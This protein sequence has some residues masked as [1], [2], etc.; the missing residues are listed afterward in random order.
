MKVEERM[1]RSTM[2]SNFTSSVHLETSTPKQEQNT[3]PL[4][5]RLAWALGLSVK[6]YTKLVAVCLARHAGS[7]TGLAWP[8]LGLISQTTGLSRS[9]V[10][11][12]VAELEQGGHLAVT[13]LKVGKKNAANRYRLPRMGSAVSA[14]PPSAEVAHN[15]MVTPP[16]VCETPP[17]VCETPPPSVCV[18]PEPVRTEP[19]KEPKQ[20]ATVPN[21]V[22]ATKSKNRNYCETHKRSWPGHYGE[23]CFLCDRESLELKSGAASVRAVFRSKGIITPADDAAYGER[24]AAFRAKM[25][26]QR[27]TDARTRNIDQERR[28]RKSGGFTSTGGLT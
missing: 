4:S 2:K 26:P 3:W 17:S 18:T 9:S 14:P 5:D 15:V 28:A 20:R 11:R 7:T 23:I 10:L 8:G 16:S 6:P 12:G 1:G 27:A 24:Q 13:R 19:V 21:Q 25:F 22:Q